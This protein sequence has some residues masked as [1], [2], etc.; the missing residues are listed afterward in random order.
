MSLD[1]AAPSTGHPFELPVVRCLREHGRLALY[2]GVTFPVGENGSGKST[3]VEAVAVAVGLNPEGGSRSF[4]FATPAAS[5]R[6]G[7]PRRVRRGA[8]R[9]S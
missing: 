1:P 5:R 8:P 7:P 3:P 9:S 2:P 6:R 4:R